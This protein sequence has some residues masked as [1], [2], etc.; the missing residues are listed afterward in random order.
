MSSEL[1]HMIRD[2]VTALLREAVNDPVVPYRMLTD[3]EGLLETLS[4]VSDD[5][6]VREINPGDTASSIAAHVEHLRFSF[7]VWERWLQGSREA[8]DWARSWIGVSA[9]AWSDLVARFEERFRSLVTTIESVE[10]DTPENVGAALAVTNHLSYH[11]GMIRQKIR[12]VSA[13]RSS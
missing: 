12:C 11:I 4:G 13:E 8:V 10:L 2:G 1:P 3:H 9:E 6:A 5:E 7:V